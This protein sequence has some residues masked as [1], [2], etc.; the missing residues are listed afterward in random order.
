VALLGKEIALKARARG[1]PIHSQ[2]R[3]LDEVTFF[4]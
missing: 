2:K 3:H 1:E 4:T